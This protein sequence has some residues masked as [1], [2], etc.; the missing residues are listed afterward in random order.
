M[1]IIQL[2]HNDMSTCS[3][4]VRLV[5]SEKNL[6]WKSHHM[7]LRAG[8][9]RTKEYIEFLNPNGVVPTL[10]WHK[11]I[12]IESTI[13]ME[14]LENNYIETPLLPNDPVK[15]AKIRLWN[16]RLDEEIHAATAVISNC[17][18]FRH[19]NL[20]NKTREEVEEMISRI[21]DE[22]KRN[23]RYDF[24]FN[25]MDSQHFSPA[26]KKFEKLFDELDKIFEDNEWLVGDI[27]S[28]ADI[29]YIPYLTRFEHLNLTSMIDK[30]KN[31]KKW[32]EKIKNRQNYSDAISNWLN[33]DYLNLMMEKG[34]EAQTKVNQILS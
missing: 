22:N 10:V 17:I 13:I 27:Y 9:T 11:D 15:V 14:F 20:K 33:Q 34:S 31:L 16:K 30:R 26:L 28:L 5:L 4:K 18:A 23:L 19:Q 24:T 2:Y 6:P 29:S 25:G 1:E 3:Q 12:I 32:F 21:P 7:N 8:D